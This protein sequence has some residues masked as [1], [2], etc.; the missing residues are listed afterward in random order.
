VVS[1]WRSR[2]IPNWLNAAI[3]L[4]AIP[5]WYVTS[6]GLWPGVAVHLGVA[7]AVFGLFAGAFAIGWMGGGDVKLLG[8][9]ALWLSPVAVLQLIVIMSLAGGVL[10]VAMAIRHRL[11]RHTG[12]LEIPYGIAI[13][14][15]GFWLISER[16]LNQFV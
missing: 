7:L 5:F 9:V 12:A 13:A 6:V 1:D 3:A 15:G 16:F 11:A 14:F 10:T 2:E 4:G 8:A